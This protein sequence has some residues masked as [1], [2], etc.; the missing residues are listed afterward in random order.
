MIK[1]FRHDGLKRLFERGSQAGVPARHVKKLRLILAVLQAATNPH[2]ANFP[3]SGLHELSGDRKGTWS[4][5]V[6][7]NWR[8]TFRFDGQDVTD[9]NFEDT[10]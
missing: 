7:G 10:H 8:V 4:V 5:D 3:G 9:V 1:R 2:D 6:S